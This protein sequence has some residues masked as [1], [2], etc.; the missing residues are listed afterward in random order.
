MIKKHIKQF[1]TIVCTIGLSILSATPTFADTCSADVPVKVREAA[2]CLGN[3]NGLP[4]VIQNILSIVIGVCGLVAVAYIIVGGYNYMTSS[5]DS[6]KIEKAKKTILYAVIGLIVCALAFIIV[7][8]VI[9]TV[10]SA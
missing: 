4:T 6:A 9:N 7:N 8:F 2:G 3:T 1:T 10:K 5:G